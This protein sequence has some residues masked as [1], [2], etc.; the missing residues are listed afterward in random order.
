MEKNL[1]RKYK[2]EDKNRIFN[3]FLAIL[4]LFKLYLRC[5]IIDEKITCWRLKF[6]TDILYQ[7]SANFFFLYKGSGSKLV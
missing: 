3:E 7:E 5:I 2:K 4:H 6:Q 1:K